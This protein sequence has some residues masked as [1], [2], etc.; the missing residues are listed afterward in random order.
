M[1]S[2][3]KK[4]NL[5]ALANQN[6][7]DPIVLAQMLGN[8]KSP[9]KRDRC[10]TLSFLLAILLTMFLRSRSN[11]ATPSEMTMASLVKFDA[12]KLEQSEDEERHEPKGG[13]L[14]LSLLFLNILLISCFLLALFDPKAVLDK[15]RK[16]AVKVPP[17]PKMLRISGKNRIHV[18]SLFSAISV[19]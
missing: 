10:A 19:I 17:K 9:E 2:E 1:E 3:G 14:P 4:K 6:Q 5:A 13:H 11:A 8:L 7:A 12:L 16:S 18:R 15:G